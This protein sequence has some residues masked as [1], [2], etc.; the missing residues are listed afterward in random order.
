MPRFFTSRID[1]SHGLVTGDDARHIA[2]SLRM[3]TGEEVTLCNNGVDYDCVLEEITPENVTCR[4]IRVSPCAAEANIRLHLF[5]A[6]PKGEKAEIIVQKAVEL[7][8][9]DIT[10]VLTS[11]CISRPDDKSFSKKLKRYNKIA[12]E[13]AKQSGRGTVPQV[14]GLITLSQAVQRMKECDSAVWCYEK[15]GAAFSELGMRPDT[16]IGLLIGSEGG[17]SEDEAERIRS[18]GIEPVGM[19]KRILRCE[20]APLAAAAIIMNLTGNM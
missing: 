9:Y 18:S 20:T 16:E 15:G 4:V 1:G 3:R 13:A 10:F 2:L 19:G 12:L 17:F 7:G 5:Q 6:V 8:V 14:N 11:R